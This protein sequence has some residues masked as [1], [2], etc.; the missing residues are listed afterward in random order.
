M[1]LEHPPHPGGVVIAQLVGKQGRQLLRDGLEEVAE[2]PERV[3]GHGHY[4][5]MVAS[6]RAQEATMAVKELGHV[7]LYVRNAERSAHF[8]RD[9]LGWHQVMPALG[10]PIQGF[11]MF[12]SGRTHHEL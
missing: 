8:Y 3:V 1:D 6:R 7:V 11:V 4:D 5:R 10:D 12:S 9:V 2:G